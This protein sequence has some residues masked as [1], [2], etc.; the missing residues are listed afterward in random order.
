MLQC[1]G[2][3]GP[4][5]QIERRRAVLGQ[6]RRTHGPNTR[7]GPRLRPSAR[8]L[9]SSGPKGQSTG[10]TCLSSASRVGQAG[11]LNGPSGP[12]E[13]K[14]MVELKRPIMPNWAYNFSVNQ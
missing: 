4:S 9:S 13:M 5:D 7:A 8:A 6:A 14:N 12:D 1:K 11:Q 10:R 3:S 2:D